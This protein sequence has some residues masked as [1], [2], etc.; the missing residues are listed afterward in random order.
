ML[1]SITE[2]GMWGDVGPVCTCSR[3]KRCTAE[4]CS[5]FTPNKPLTVSAASTS[6]C[7]SRTILPV[8]AITR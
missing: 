4:S 7:R 8:R 6:F 1:P 2:E 3:S 5:F